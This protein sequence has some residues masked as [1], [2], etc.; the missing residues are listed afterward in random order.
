MRYFTFMEALA[1]W[2]RQV[3]TSRAQTETAVVALT[4]RFSGIVRRIEAALGVHERA[5]RHDI[6][7]EV[8]ESEQDLRLVMDGLRAIQRSRDELAHEIRG[9][10]A[11]AEELRQMGSEVESIAFQTNMLALN[12]AIEAAHAGEMGKGF[13]VVAH[14]VRDLSNAAR[15]TGRRISQKVGLMGEALGRIGAT[16]EQVQQRDLRE[17]ESSEGHIQAVLARFEHSSTQL[18][19]S[20]RGQLEQSRAVKSEIAESLVQL[21]FQDRVNQILSQVVS[22]IARLTDWAR[23]GAPPTDAAARRRAHAF[24]AGMTSS[25]TTEEQRRNHQGLSARGPATR[26]VTFF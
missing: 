10:A 26:A 3:E 15:E 5:G 12:A 6:A 9:L 2:G 21:Q 17:V 8:R 20:A 4:E 24:V 13:A 14:E 19:E 11:H 16:S 23:A 7:A 25:Y 1:I 22:S 18:A